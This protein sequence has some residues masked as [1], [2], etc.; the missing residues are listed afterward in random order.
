MNLGSGQA[1][2]KRT[3]RRNPARKAKE[4]EKERTEAAA[5]LCRRNQGCAPGRHFRGAGAGVGPQQA[6]KGAAILPDP[7]GRRVLDSQPRRQG[8]HRRDA[9]RRP[10]KITL[11]GQRFAALPTFGKAELPVTL[12]HGARTESEQGVIAAEAQYRGWM[13]AGL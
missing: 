13:L 5:A 6:A 1:A 9:W 10:Q 12:L 11:F 7:P 3:A 4:N 8:L 2:S